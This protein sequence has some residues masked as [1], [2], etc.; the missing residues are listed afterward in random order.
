MTFAPP[1]PGA[2]DPVPGRPST[3]VGGAST[4]TVLAWIGFA[5][6]AV[7]TGTFTLLTITLS[8]GPG[9]VGVGAVLAL[10]P[11][12]PVVAFYLWLDRWEREPPSLLAFAFIWGAAVATFGAL[13]LNTAA[14]LLLMSA[15]SGPTVV[16]VVVAP[17]VEELFKGLAVLLVFLLRRHEFDGVVDGLV[18]AGLVGVGFAFVENILYLGTALAEDGS[19]GLAATFVVRCLFSPF[20]HPLFTSATG[21]GI[22]LAARSRRTSVQVLA[23]LT[24]YLVAVSLHSLWNYSASLGSSFVELYVLVQVPLFAAFVVLAVVSRRR[25]ARVVSTHMAEYAAAGW[26]DP[27]DAAMLGSMRVRH[28]ARRWAA[29]VAGPE[30]ARQM[31]RFQQLA[32]ELAFLRERRVRGTA[33][34]TAAAQEYAGLVGLVRLRATLPLPAPLGA[35]R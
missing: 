14:D 2:P 15:G 4:L 8:T 6:L 1:T 16:S 26:V 22:G 33:G 11:V 18:Y 20:A 34:P 35:G 27:T 5:L 17:L 19:Q 7:V 9:A 23:P 32:S 25:E 12:V 24:G 21:I 13:L 3:A 28:A 29:R 10:I 31:R 30:G